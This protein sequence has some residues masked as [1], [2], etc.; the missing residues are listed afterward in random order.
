[1]PMMQL[2]QNYINVSDIYLSGTIIRDTP[3]APNL[4]W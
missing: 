4:S 1:M 2:E 3:S